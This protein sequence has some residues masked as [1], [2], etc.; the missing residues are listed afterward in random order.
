M[1]SIVM[2]YLPVDIAAILSAVLTFV[3]LIVVAKI[4]NRTKQTETTLGV[5]NHGSSSVSESLDLARDSVAAVHGEVAGMHQE[6]RQ[7]SA[8]L[9]SFRENAN[10]DFRDLRNQVS[11]QAERIGRLEQGK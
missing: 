6:M 11:R 4:N 9:D 5:P 7:L 2:Q 8:R 1:S 3:A 10:T